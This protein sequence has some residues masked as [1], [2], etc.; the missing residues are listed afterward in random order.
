MVLVCEH[1]D[2]LALSSRFFPTVCLFLSLQIM[3]VIIPFRVSLIACSCFVRI[4]S[5]LSVQ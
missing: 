4:S 5:L 3:I 2:V 1:I